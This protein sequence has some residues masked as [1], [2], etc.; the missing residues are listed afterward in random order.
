MYTLI[1][2]CR[3]KGSMESRIREDMKRRLGYGWLKKPFF[4][5]QHNWEDRVAEDFQWQLFSSLFHW[6]SDTRWTHNYFS[7]LYSKHIFLQTEISVP[8]R[9]HGRLQYIHLM[10]ST[11]RIRAGARAHNYCDATKTLLI[12]TTGTKFKDMKCINIVGISN[13]RLLQEPQHDNFQKFLP[14]MLK[15]LNLTYI[16]YQLV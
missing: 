16:F 7:G 5:Y 6:L 13:C 14:N 9:T 12:K 15:F 3:K 2:L 4:L 11:V 8:C 1:G 10:S